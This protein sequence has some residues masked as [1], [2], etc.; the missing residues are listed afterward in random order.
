MTGLE[1]LAALGVA[2]GATAQAVTGFGFALVAA[3]ALVAALGPTQGVSVVCVL[4]VLASVLPYAREARH[5]DW[6]AVA[7]WWVPTLVISLLLGAALAGVDARLLSALSG[8]AVIVAVA[9]LARGRTSVRLAG[10]RG[11][12][13]A[14]AVSGAMNLIGGVGGPPVALYAAN[15]GWPIER[16]RPTLLAFFAVQNA[17]TVAVIGW[18]WPSAALVVALVVALVIGSVL[19]V[20]LASRLDAAAVRTA[21]LGVAAA[22]GAALIAGALL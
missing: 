20:A 19:G 5:T 22:G 9:L 13:L 1:W 15:A 3:P 11:A 16:V 17:V 4:G 12:V 6:R 7:L 21:V 8:V 18:V 14:G 2:A 10:R